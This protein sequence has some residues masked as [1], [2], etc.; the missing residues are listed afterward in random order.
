MFPENLLEDSFIDI[1]YFKLSIGV[2]LSI[3]FLVLLLSNKEILIFRNERFTLFSSFFFLRILPFFI[4]YIILNFDARSDVEMFYESALGAKRFGFVYRDFESAYSP[5]F[6]YITALPLFL[7]NSPK[8]IIL[9][10]IIVECAIVWFTINHYK[11]KYALKLG[12]LYLLLP[13]SFVFSVLGGQEDIWMWLFILIG[14]YFSKIKEKPFY[15]GLALGFGLLITKALLVLY[16]PAILVFSKKP[17]HIF[18]GLLLIGIPSLCFLYLH[19]EFLFLSP[20]QQANDPRTPNIWS[21]I[22]PLSNGFIPIGPKILNWLGLFTIQSL[23]IY[24]A[25]KLKNRIP[26]S[27]FLLYNFLI[28]SIWLMIIQQSS[29]AN[30]AYVYLLPLIFYLK[31]EKSKKAI[32]LLLFFNVLIIVQPALWWG[33]KMPVFHSLSEINLPFEKIEYSLE[34][35]ILGMLFWLL[36]F[37]INRLKKI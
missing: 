13:G 15:L 14:I 24:F 21:V 30:Y 35:L 37:V 17:L 2:L 28:I 31:L 3:L 22:H 4:I 33:L 26:M 20:I 27:E 10:M 6:A 32:L 7:W 19:S 16:I 23:G 11:S 34:V 18:Y 9:F 25:V 36:F 1:F 5:L 12:I 29:L 8:A